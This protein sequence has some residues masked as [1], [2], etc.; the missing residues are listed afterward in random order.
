MK[1]QQRNRMDQSQHS[2]RGS[3]VRRSVHLRLCYAEKPVEPLRLSDMG[4]HGERKR[5]SPANWR[6]PIVGTRQQRK[7]ASDTAC[8]SA[9]LAGPPQPG[10]RPRRDDSADP[11]DKRRT[12][13]RLFCC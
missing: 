2:I 7:Q 5:T 4:P 6:K 11:F 12:T 1:G 8:S 3:V 9:S 13:G 10:A